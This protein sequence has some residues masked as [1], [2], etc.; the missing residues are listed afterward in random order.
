MKTKKF[1]T[2][3]LLGGFIL[4]STMPA[5]AESDPLTELTNETGSSIKDVL[6]QPEQLPPVSDAGSA[7]KQ[8]KTDKTKKLTA[9][10]KQQLE[11]SKTE[12]TTL[13]N[14]IKAN[15][16]QIVG[17]KNQA[18]S[19][20]QEIKQLIQAKRGTLKNTATASAIDE[21]GKK[22]KKA[23]K[24]QVLPENLK[25]LIGQLKS[26]REKLKATYEDGKAIRDAIKQAHEGKDFASVISGLKEIIKIQETRVQLLGKIIDDLNAIKAA[27]A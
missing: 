9:E 23:A 14:E 3:M 8:L 12:I 20:N 1:L 11:A 4:A 19:L 5:F 6:N 22:I 24:T 13:R 16:E 27:L 26:D 18:K 15:H 17:L 21:N 2:S 10:Q 7:V 25:A